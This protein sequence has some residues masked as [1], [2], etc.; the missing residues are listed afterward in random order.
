MVAGPQSRPVSLAAT[1]VRRKRAQLWPLLPLLLGGRHR[2]AG[3]C[4]WRSAC[5]GGGARG[6][7][8]EG[9]QVV[10]PGSSGGWGKGWGHWGGVGGGTADALMWMP[11]SARLCVR[12]WGRAEAA[13]AQRGEAV[14]ESRVGARGTR[15]GNRNPGNRKPPGTGNRKPP[16]AVPVPAGLPHDL[17]PGV[18]SATH[19]RQTRPQRSPR[20]APPYNN[21]LSAAPRET[22]TRDLF[23]AL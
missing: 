2:A 9:R 10:G 23:P 21:R 12:D 8:E 16:W 11:P 18:T 6:A 7:R 13:I 19:W 15:G 4:A 17:P 22:W 20:P 5:V 1:A 3:V 14:T